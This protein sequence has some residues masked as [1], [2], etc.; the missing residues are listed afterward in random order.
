[1]RP[2]SGVSG[3]STD[4]GNGARLC[5]SEAIAGDCVGKVLAAAA[6]RMDCRVVAAETAGG[7]GGGSAW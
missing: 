2:L 1:M 6:V 4:W 5:P 7:C 3:I